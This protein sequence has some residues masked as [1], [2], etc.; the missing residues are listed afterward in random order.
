M[1]TSYTSGESLH[2]DCG[3]FSAFPGARQAQPPLRLCLAGKTAP[4]ASCLLRLTFQNG[5]K[6]SDKY[7]N[8]SN[9]LTIF[10]KTYAS[11]RS[12]MSKK[13]L[14]HQSQ[15]GFVHLSHSGKRPHPQDE[16]AFLDMI[17]LRLGQHSVQ[18]YFCIFRHFFFNGNEMMFFSFFDGLQT[19]DKMGQVNAVHGQT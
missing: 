18:G 4:P 6:C 8:V 7:K 13:K 3:R 12:I 5:P 16:T 14:F 11:A 1:R 17:P 10:T 9:L 2:W 19:P 15:A